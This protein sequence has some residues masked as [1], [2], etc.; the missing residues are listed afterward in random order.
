MHCYGINSLYIVKYVCVLLEGYSLY[1]LCIFVCF[2]VHIPLG[3][4]SPGDPQV[5]SRKKTQ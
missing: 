2:P 5:R 4:W 3:A 1:D